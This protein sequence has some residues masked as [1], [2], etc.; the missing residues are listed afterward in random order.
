MR[1]TP[2]AVALCVG[3]VVRYGCMAGWIWEFTYTPPKHRMIH[4]AILRRRGICR[5]AVIMTGIERTIISVKRFN[6]AVET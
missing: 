5:R 1:Q 3:W 2:T 6:A 4:T